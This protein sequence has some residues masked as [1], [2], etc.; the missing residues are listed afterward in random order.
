WT[1]DLAAA[2][3]L[4]PQR[5]SK[6][7]NNFI[8]NARIVLTVVRGKAINGHPIRPEQYI[9]DRKGASEV[10]IAAFRQR[11][12]MPAVKHRRRQH[13]FER[14]KRPVQIGVHEGGMEGG[15][16]TDP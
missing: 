10:G 3:R 15:E 11:G 7:S 14:P 6:L 5:V 12:V 9:P 4:L 2:P 13:I 1:R 8:R 16:R